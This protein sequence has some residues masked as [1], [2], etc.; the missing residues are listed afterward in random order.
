MAEIN[1]LKNPLDTNEIEQYHYNGPLIDWLQEVAPTGFGNPIRTFINE[2]ELEI[3]DLDREVGGNDTVLI[4]VMPATGAEFGAFLLQMFASMAV[5]FVVGKIFGPTLPLTPE[6][7]DSK[8]DNP[9]YALSNPQNASRIGEPIPV[10]YGDVVTT[11]DYASEPFYSYYTHD[12]NI[13]SS[14]GDHVTFDYDVRFEYH[15]GHGPSG[16]NRLR[17]NYSVRLRV[18]QAGTANLV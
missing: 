7:T 2:E 14:T 9:V 10:I 4:L 3:K 13:V 12:G 1:L 15:H 18:R 8:I 5:S 17:F 11:P 6:F 16:T